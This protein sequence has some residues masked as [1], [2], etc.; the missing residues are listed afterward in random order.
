MFATTDLSFVATEDK[1]EV[2]AIYLEVPEPKALFVLAHGAGANMQHEHMTRLALSLA[3][4]QISSLRF[5]FPFMQDGGGRTD[6]KPVCL[7]TISNA[8]SL[9]MQQ[10]D[11]R[12]VLSG[13]SFG[14]RM[15]SHLAAEKNCRLEGLVYFSFPL[16]PSRKPSTRRA[17]HLPGINLPQLFVSGTRDSLA[18]LNLLKSLVD[19]LPRA[20]LY[21]LETADH[22]F[23]ILKRTRVSTEDVY[24]EAARAACGWLENHVDQRE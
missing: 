20:S 12:I 7:E 8:I 5:N 2:S 9:A 24:D 10:Q 21:L 17:E 23:K 14:G 19:H 6:S 4:Q 22:S 13:H 16:H 18:D 3:G 11:G 15:G 1:G